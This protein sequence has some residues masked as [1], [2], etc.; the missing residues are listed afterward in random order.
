[1]KTVLIT[2]ASGLIGSQLTRHLL[3]RKYTVH[4]LTRNKKMFKHKNVHPFEWDIEKGTMEPAALE[5]VEAIIHLAGAGVAEKRWSEERKKELSESRLKSTRL[6]YDFLQQYPHTVKTIISA[7]AVGYYGDRGA[8]VLN[9][10]MP[11]GDGFLAEL[12]RKW[13]DEVMRFAKIGVREVRC[14]IGI[15]LASAGGALPELIKT[16]PLGFVPYFDK[17]ELY[18]PWIHID[19]VCGIMLYALENENLSGAFNVTA[20]APLPMKALMQKVLEVKSSRA[21]LVPAPPVVIRLAMGEMSEM[22]LSS[23]RCS[24]QKIQ[25]AG[26]RFQYPD[27]ISALKQ[28]FGKN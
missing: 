18:Y 10:E 14:R 24:A 27:A 20:P 25:Q 16:L 11:P 2:G 28:I 8:E 9:E 21:M 1:M 7:S 3:S 12:C 26:Y 4:T 15:V 19:D 17:K 6:L 22:L 13:E 23:E 5:G